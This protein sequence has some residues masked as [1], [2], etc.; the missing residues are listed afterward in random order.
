MFKRPYLESAALTRLQDDTVERISRRLQPGSWCPGRR[1]SQ[2]GPNGLIFFDLPFEVREMIYG[3]IVKNDEPVS[4]TPDWKEVKE[5]LTLNVGGQ[6][7]TEARAVFHRINTFIVHIGDDYHSFVQ[8]D[9]TQAPP[10]VSAGGY[11]F[12]A[13]QLAFLTMT[14]WAGIISAQLYS[15]LSNDRIPL[16]V[17]RRGRGIW[18]LEYRLAN[19]LIPVSCS[20]SSPSTSSTAKSSR[21]IA[22]KSRLFSE[23]FFAITSPRTAVMNGRPVRIPRG[24]VFHNPRLSAEEDF[25]LPTDL[26]VV[27]RN[28]KGWELVVHPIKLSAEFMARLG[29]VLSNP[30]PNSQMRQRHALTHPSPGNTRRSWL[31]TSHEVSGIRALGSYR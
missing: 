3:Y 23:M 21:F 16:A 20:P 8:G 9:L 19:T 12:A 5:A 26:A 2:W 15:Y 1:R 4:I 18:R 11:G 28:M 27:S 7:E 31:C 6:M 10:S 17:A 25:R 22:Q 13:L 29:L 30:T 24:S 14:A